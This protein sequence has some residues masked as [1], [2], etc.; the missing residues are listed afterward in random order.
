VEGALMLNYTKGPW[1]VWDDSTMTSVVAEN[2]EI[3]DIVVDD[4]SN[5]ENL[6]NAYLI[7]LAPTMFELLE[8]I[9]DKI[10]EIVDVG[11]IDDLGQ[12]AIGTD[13]TA[14]LLTIVNKIIALKYETLEKVGKK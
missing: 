12:L 8:E 9:T 7:S 3:C 11:G 6:S 13:H 5:Y 2:A 10:K 1:E 14:E 4:R